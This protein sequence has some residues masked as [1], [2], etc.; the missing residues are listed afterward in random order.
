MAAIGKSVDW[1]LTTASRALAAQ[2]PSPC[3]RYARSG[4]D[5]SC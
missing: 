4:V 1:D 3:N 5:F 2:N